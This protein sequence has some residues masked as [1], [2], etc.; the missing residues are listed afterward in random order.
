MLRE[1][2][3][4]TELG[5]YVH[6]VGRGHVRRA[7]T[8]AAELRHRL[9]CR[10]TGLSSL[11]RPERWPGPWVRLPPDDTGPA[12]QDPTAGGRLHWTPLH[13]PGVR[14]RARALSN[15]FAE[16]RPAL[17]VVDVS[18]ETALLARLHGVPVVSVV[19]PGDRHD[20]AHQLGFDVAQSLVGFWPAGTTTPI[21]SAAGGTAERVRAVGGMS[22]VASPRV[23]S[24]RARTVVALS[25]LGGQAWTDDELDEAQAASPGWE[26]TR[27]GPGRWVDDPGEALASAEVVVAHAGQNAV[28]DVAAV[29]RPLIVVPAGRPHDEQAATGRALASGG[30][31]AIVLTSLGAA[32]WPDVLDRAAGMPG[33][34]WAGWVD[35]RAAERFTDE[36]GRV[37]HEV[38]R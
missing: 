33:E 31:P 19:L 38:V 29:R 17:V 35:G 11:P 26:W 30:W 8:L 24:V 14:E 4:T 20:P 15:W 7:T 16:A 5:Y 21:F 13:D 37:L 27:L 18:V 12:P 22:A 34:Q 25:G 1:D 36:V 2:P 3:V 32:D 28:A 23:G 6:H 9:G 10:V